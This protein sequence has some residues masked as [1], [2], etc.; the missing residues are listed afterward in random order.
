MNLLVRM[1]KFPKKIIFCHYSSTG[2]KDAVE[3]LKEKSERFIY[4]LLSFHHVRS[5]EKTTISFYQKGEEVLKKGYFAMHPSGQKIF[6][7]IPV[8]Y[9]LHLINIL[10]LV[11]LVKEPYDLFIGQN[12]FCVFGGILLK[13]LGKVKETVYWVGDYFPIPPSG[14][15]HY[16]LK[17]FR[18]FD[19][20]SLKHSDHVWFMTPRLLEVREKEGLLPKRERG[21]FRI[22]SSPINILGPRDA[23]LKKASFQS[24]V[25]LG[26]LSEN[27]GV[28]EII[29]V[30]P[31]IVKEIP[32]F[33]F[34]II[35]S[36][37]YENE[38][39]KLVLRLHLEK[40][41]EFKGFVP[42]EGEVRRIIASAGVAIAL[43][44]PDEYSFTQFADSGKI[45][46]YLSCGV[47]V[48]ST[49]VPY[50]AKEVE[51]RRAGIV[52]NFDPE[53]LAKVLIKIL[54]DKKYNIRC[55]ENAI[56]IAKTYS[57]EN[58]FR[59]VLGFPER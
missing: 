56:K 4:L 13:R 57:A 43:Y 25:F 39:K 52:V 17:V 2:N 38:L 34:T 51:E 12:Y 14:P 10:R 8:I 47:P 21:V 59:D 37:Y 49:S 41:V 32:G 48:V 22:V 46:M 58:V 26:V 15:Y 18:I 44:K 30:I 31:K 36:G 5:N 20:F 33:T 40:H 35:G 3:Y 7:L 24:A 27:Q 53:E 42:T 29:Q 1:K 11:Y 54:S 19:K 9:F 6:L 16:F 45:K 23:Q 28:Q 50:I 55:R